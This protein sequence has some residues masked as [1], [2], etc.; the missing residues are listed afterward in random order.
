MQRV[1]F[2]LVTIGIFPLMQQLCS[3][4][5]GAA[6]WID[7]L[8]NEKLSI[9]IEAQNK[10]WKAG[11][12]IQKELEQAAL[13]KNPETSLRI[14]AIIRKIKLGITPDSP[15]EIVS[16]VESFANLSTD[17]KKSA[18][19]KLKESRQWR[20]ALLL[21]QNENDNIAKS[22]MRENVDGIAIVAARES[23]LAGDTATARKFLD[24]FS[25]D[26]KNLMAK[27]W[28]ARSDGTL[29]KEIADCS[30]LNDK[31][32]IAYH[33]CLLRVKGDRAAAIDLA[34][35]NNF[36]STGAAL[37]LLDGQPDMWLEL[38]APTFDSDS[39]ELL[40][41]Y[42]ALVKDRSNSSKEHQSNV[43]RLIKESLKGD[44]YQQRWLATHLLYAL[45][46]GEHADKALKALNPVMLFDQYVEQERI[47]EAIQI[48]GLD[49]VKPDY[50]KWLSKR[51]S[52][53]IEK[54]DLVENEMEQIPSVLSFLEKRGITDVIDKVFVPQMLALAEKDSE[55]FTQMLQECFSPY[56]KIRIAP[57][58]ALKVAIAYAKDDD[59]LWGTMIQTALSENNLFNQ[60]W[61]WIAKLYPDATKAQ[62]FSDFLTLFRIIP[63]RQNHVADMNSKIE[64]F[65]KDCDANEINTY[66]KL[67]SVIAE[68]TG[69]TTYAQWSA[70][71]GNPLG[72]DELLKLERWEDAEKELQLLFKK[73]PDAI[74]LLLRIS[75]CQNLLGKTEEAKKN[76]AL[77]ESLILGDS[78]MMSMTAAINESFGLSK[79]A[80]EWRQT[81]L[82]CSSPSTSAWLIN[83]YQE[84]EKQM[85]DGQWSQARSGYE[86]YLISVVNQDS[87]NLGGSILFRTR[88]K[89]DMAYA[90]GQLKKNPEGAIKQLKQIHQSLLSDASLADQFFPCLRLVGLRDQH[91]LWFEE[92]WQSMMKL[93][94]RFPLD[95]NTR[96]S[97]AWL[98]ARSLLRLDEAEKESIEALRLRPNQA[99]YLDTMAEIFFARGNREKAIEWSKKSIMAEPGAAALMEQ[100]YRFL[101]DEFPR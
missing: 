39:R 53:I 49:P 94:N 9:R 18:I 60:W 32:S 55:S 19:E 79:I 56:S 75:I 47:D 66:R 82:T 80:S 65:L 2:L 77:Y 7:Q 30:K 98:A 85:L 8:S 12:S 48:L 33:L 35:K 74:D 62:R 95:D 68:I 36:A 93:R 71:E 58:S 1:F 70:E 41:I 25:D 17:D 101:H 16:L 90:F 84:A 67:V 73:S 89:A 22:Q 38:R 78:S 21:F 91:D 43:N 97:A 64:K 59:V 13:S 51:M 99:A 14:A 10:L 20:I 24:D 69:N 96:N 46:L 54:P 6:E 72:I 76:A 40:E 26:S 11:A 23:L 50:E 28:M 27:A 92:T 83:V 15:K 81:T 31:K 57:E 34:E 29:E 61:D 100:Y 3:A 37:Q 44:D 4:E 88:K 45:G 86:A 42:I 52:I 63:D 5:D 87:E